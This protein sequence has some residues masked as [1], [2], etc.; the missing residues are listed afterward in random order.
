M[1]VLF[2]LYGVLLDHERMF[3][4]YREK[5][6]GLL[7]VRFGG[8]PEVWRRAHDDAFI[9]YVNRVGDAN[10]DA[11]GWAEIVDELD[12][13]NLLEILDRVGVAERPPDPLGLSRSLERE[14]MAAVD[15]RFPDA[16]PAIERLRSAGH[17]VHVATGGGETA[18]AALRGAGLLGLVGS[19]FTGHSQNA[20]KGRPA[21]WRPIPASLRASAPD[22]VLVDDRLDYLE[23]AAS[24]GI[25]ALLLDRKGA[26]RPESMP[27]FLAATLR[28][29][30]AV[31]HWVAAHEGAARG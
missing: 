6:A 9:A 10:W 24:T 30:A 2:D 13:R 20:P 16:R 22:C 27:S 8:E 19:L 3:R 23:A 31:P 7:A 5:F 28:N 21:Y 11:R 14:A 26:H 25:H 4:E 12:A 17:G 29:L 1:H 18:D 15:A